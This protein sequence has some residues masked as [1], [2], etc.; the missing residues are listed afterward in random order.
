L[1][2]EEAPKEV[3]KP[4][5]SLLYF[6]SEKFSRPSF[7]FY[8]TANQFLANGFCMPEKLPVKD[9]VLYKHFVILKNLIAKKLNKK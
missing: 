6:L 7:I 4:P 1:C 9:A 5:E 2:F 3:Q 8:L